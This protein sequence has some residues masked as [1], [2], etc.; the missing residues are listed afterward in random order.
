[1]SEVIQINGTDVKIVK[2]DISM[3][4]IESFVFYAQPSLALGSG[5]G[6]AISTRGGPSI[7]KE[8]DTMEKRNAGDVVFTT[9]GNLKAKYIFHAVGPAFQEEDSENKLRTAIFNTLIAADE[10]GVKSLAFPM[11]GA[12][13]YGIAPDSSI[14]IMFDCIRR[15][16]NNKSN[17]KEIVICAN[18]NREYRLFTSKTSLLK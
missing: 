11:M 4:D 6:N 18:D 2:D 12:G 9:A 13:F 7:K 15:H 8:L 5:Y 10:K 14:T 17:L 16:L 1:M 3:L